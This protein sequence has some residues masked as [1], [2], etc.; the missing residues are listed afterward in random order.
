MPDREAIVIGKK[1]VDASLPSHVPGVHEGNWP[2][3]APRRRRVRGA[4]PT[5]TGAPRRSTGIAPEKHGPIDPRM[6]N[7]TPP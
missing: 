3:R 1:Q 6:P 5:L 7:L 2:S 4:D